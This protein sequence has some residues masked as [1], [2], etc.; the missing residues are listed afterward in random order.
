MTSSASPITST[1]ACSCR[2]ARLTGLEPEEPSR[3]AASTLG[4]SYGR[5]NRYSSC[6][7]A[8]G[9]TAHPPRRCTWSTGAHARHPTRG[10]PQ[11]DPTPPATR[12]PRPDEPQRSR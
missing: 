3:P 1:S 8:L 4:F 7:A 10:P 5:L 11:T 6:R 9:P 12:R 2:W